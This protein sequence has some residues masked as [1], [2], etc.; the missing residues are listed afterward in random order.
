[1]TD[2]GSS[3]PEVRDLLRVLASGRRVAEIG[4]AFGE[5]AAA[6][7][8]SA[9][10]V[11]TVE[12]DPG[13]LEIARGRLAGAPNVEL[14]AGDWHELLPPRGPFDLVFADGGLRT[15][16]DYESLLE[17]VAQGGL[18]VKDDLTP[19]RA[20]EGDE[21]REFLLRDERIVGVEI[22]TAPG[23]A[24]IVAARRS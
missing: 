4:T 14:L 15:R 9:R 12:L 20:A 21:V 23:H 16:D 7:A 6:M 13:R 2:G 17:L 3:I 18:I 8:T 1:V 19:G 24:A 22:V 5:G 10:E 11:I